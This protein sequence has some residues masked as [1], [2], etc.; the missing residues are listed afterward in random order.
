MME[1]LKGWAR[2][3]IVTLY[4]WAIMILTVA[5][6]AI[7]ALPLAYYFPS[8]LEGVGLVRD[9]VVYGLGITAVSFVALVV[10]S[11]TIPD[12]FWKWIK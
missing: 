1:N 2:I 10:G 4:G 12:K 7:P 5:I 11:Q 8:G 9:T 6:V 3:A